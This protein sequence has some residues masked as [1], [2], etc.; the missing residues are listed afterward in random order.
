[1]A[2]FLVRRLLLAALL[3]FVVSSAS[4]VLISLTPG[5]YVTESL[6]LNASAATQQRTRAAYGLD[7]PVVSQYGAWLWRAVRF[8]F[9]RSLMYDRPVSD[10]L[11]ERA[12]NSALLA[13]SALA[14]ATLLGVPFGV[15]T[16]SRG[17][18]VVA[19]VGRLISIAFVSAPPLLASLMLVVLATRTGWVP[20]GGMYSAASTTR[21]PV[22]L[23]AHMIVPVLALALP[24][25]AQFER[26]QSQS[27]RETIALPFVTAAAARGIP[28]RRIV[29][30]DALRVSLKPVV[31]LYGIA[32]GSLLSGSFVVE[33][34]TGWPGLG[35]LM[36]DALRSRDLYLAA[37]C[38]ATGAVF[39]AFGTFLSDLALAVLDPRTRE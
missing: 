37:G 33:M 5:D 24:L 8:D 36:F 26:L 15:L 31:A 28:W 3:V 38:A 7:R 35:R 2:R 17:S 30:R 1:M 20:V 13:G 18:S 10:L 32:I 22:D 21:S 16:G 34:M 29:W 9:G 14:L 39:L 27:M 11:P 23:L 6:G 12:L 25:A 4:L 19:S